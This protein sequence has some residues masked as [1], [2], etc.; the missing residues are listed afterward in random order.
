MAHRPDFSDNASLAVAT[1]TMA[2]H[3]ALRVPK[4]DEAAEAI[5]QRQRPPGKRRRH[6][7]SI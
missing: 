4:H 5:E 1:L 2:W 6:V 3:Y 7:E